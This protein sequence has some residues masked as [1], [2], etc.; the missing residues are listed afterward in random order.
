MNFLF[1]F[2]QY[3]TELISWINQLIKVCWNSSI[4]T[5]NRPAKSVV[6]EWR[7]NIHCKR[8]ERFFHVIVT[9]NRRGNEIITV[10]DHLGILYMDIYSDLMSGHSTVQDKV[11]IFP[12]KAKEHIVYIPI[13][14]FIDSLCLKKFMKC[15]I[16]S[17][18]SRFFF[19]FWVKIGPIS[20]VSSRIRTQDL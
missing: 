17:R 13:Q 15:G 11:A 16:F 2:L 7:Q 9:G 12:E 14:Y 1:L 8:L 20:K 4:T 10:R 18:W 3:F 5:W 6:S 19:R